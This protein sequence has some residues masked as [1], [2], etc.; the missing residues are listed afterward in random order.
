MAPIIE[1]HRGQ[2]IIG[3]ISTSLISARRAL[4]VA[5]SLCAAIVLHTAPSVSADTAEARSTMEVALDEGLLRIDAR[6]APL[7]ELLR[8][9]GEAAGFVTI[10]EGNLD[11]TI[12]R[13][14]SGVPLVRAIRDLVG[15][16]SMV[17]IHHA[18]DDEVLHVAE[19]RVFAPRAR[20]GVTD[21]P[22]PSASTLAS[23]DEEALAEL[24]RPERGAR[25][26]AV[27]RLARATGLAAVPLLSNVLER[28][29]D[30]F[31]RGNAAAAL[32]EIKGESAVTFLARAL[33]DEAVSVRLNAVRA[34]GEVGSEEAIGILGD[35]LLDHPDRRLRWLAARTLGEQRHEGARWFLEGA[36]LESDRTVR[37]EVERSL[38]QWQ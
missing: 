8:A 16:H 11:T 6:D 15:D 29:E 23:L 38:A 20:T 9:I 30:R 22:R 35:I 12:T 7:A 5:L 25:I 27:Q 28:D 33:E 4:I 34:L 26:R 36:A 37:T 2:T 19:L 18:T 10:I 17:M 24:S 32:G 31:V 21:Q 3:P 13:R 1:T 14:F